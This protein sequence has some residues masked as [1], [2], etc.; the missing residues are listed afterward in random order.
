MAKDRPLEHKMLAASFVIKKDATKG[1]VEAI[2]SVTGVTDYHGDVIVEGAFKK[3]ISERGRK[4][5]VLN[6]HNSWSVFDVI[7]V[8][9]EMREV[10][11]DELPELLLLQYPDATGGLLT[12]TQYLL[13]TPEGAGAFAR[14]DAGAIDEY[15]IGFQCMQYEWKKMEDGSTVRLI[16][17][18]KMFEYSPVI[19]GA[20]PATA[21]VGVKSDDINLSREMRAAGELTGTATRVL[22][23]GRKISAANAAKLKT[24]LDALMAIMDES[25]LLAVD[26]TLEEESNTDSKSTTEKA[27]PSLT[28]ETPTSEQPDTTAIDLAAKRAEML[29]NIRKA[30]AS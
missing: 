26:D 4:C 10:G 30:K 18:V 5:K 21:T 25:G 11:R 13:N 12:V 17:E 14:I 8:C 3:T 6:H 15:S 28:E 7:G 27:G 19:W 24:A 23:A 22:K 29:A 20:N 1:I 9:I 16:K 2:V